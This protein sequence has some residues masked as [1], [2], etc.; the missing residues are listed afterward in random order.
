MT[1]PA[2]RAVRAP[3]ATTV[4]F[5]LLVVTVLAT[6]SFV[7]VAVYLSLPGRSGELR[8]YLDRCTTMQENDPDYVEFPMSVAELRA[9]DAV[10]QRWQTCIRPALLPQLG[11][12]GSGLAI[13]TTLAGALFLAQPWWMTRRRRLH[14]LLARDSPNLV[15][16]LDGLRVEMGLRRA[17]VWQV[18]P[19]GT[20]AGG[21]AF[22]LPGRRRVQ[23]DP[24]LLLRHTT[25]RRAF[26]A[27]VLHELAHLR[28]RDVDKTYLTVN[29]WRAFLIVAVLPFL[30]VTLYPELLTGEWRWSWQTSPLAVDTGSTLYRLGSLLVLTF[31]V[32]TT[33]NAVLRVRELHADVTAAAVDGADSELPAVLARLPSPTGQWRRWLDL[34][35]THPDPVQRADTVRDPRRLLTLGRWEL[36]GT[37]IAAGMFC[38]NLNLLGGVY[39]GL[40]VITGVALI[41]LIAGAM[42]T[43]MLASSAWRTAALAPDRPPAAA[44]LLLGPIG[45]AL[46]FALG[47][48][49]SLQALT[50]EPLADL[51][52]R[53]GSWLAATLLLGMGLVAL[54]AWVD[55]TLRAAQA[56]TGPAWVGPGTV[57]AATVAGATMLSVWL[58]FSQA[59]YGFAIVAGVPATGRDLG[60]Y[61]GIVAV[62]AA[63]LGPIDRL[64][65]HPLTP[66]GLTLLWL[67]PLLGRGRRLAPIQ[68]LS[69][70]TAFAMLLTS[71]GGA[72]TIAVLPWLAA[73]T[74][75]IELRRDPP[76]GAVGVPFYVALNDAE[77][78]VGSLTVAVVMVI[79]ASRA[80]RSRAGPVVAAGIG[81][82]ILS[83]ISKSFVAYPLACV[84]NVWDLS[85]E[86]TSCIR[87]PSSALLA[88]NFHWIIV[89][90]LVFGAPCAIIAAWL[91]RHRCVPWS[92]SSGAHARTAP[93]DAVPDLIA[94][95][96]TAL[97][98]GSAAGL[99]I[100]CGWLSWAN[101]PAVAITWSTL[102]GVTT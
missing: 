51:L 60:W 33:R 75:P 9:K 74:V 22:G 28:N 63:T 18:A 72:I 17:P 65:Y 86:P 92:P 39:L 47:S 87:P 79:A 90:G 37:G 14:P 78:M 53:P 32:L 102:L 38:G 91:T 26:R 64:V 4:L 61:T 56:S 77:L 23:L 43:A 41:G 10:W 46:A 25:D 7:F 98:A 100:V 99:I 58:P 19:F 101:L 13:L 88:D 31:L 95:V 67:V 15:G 96:R 94:P 48:L 30:I 85:P 81:A 57:I 44:E 5:A 50:S 29:I 6:S 1:V 84:L 24:G 68:R 70:S 45:L 2:E 62:V 36:V 16:S 66:L 89:P 8:S 49:L 83:T 97:V 93:P 71:L 69:R 11:F 35:G 73:R 20:T 42:A 40:N 21:Q 27:V 3:A 82:A 59:S 12:V 55:S 54:T 76:Q 34:W 52:E 80:S